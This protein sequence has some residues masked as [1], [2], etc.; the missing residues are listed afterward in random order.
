[1]DDAARSDP[2]VNLPAPRYA[3]LY[4]WI[5]TH[6]PQT[7]LE[8]GIAQADNAWNMLCLTRSSA[9]YYGFDLF[10]PAP[11]HEL[12][13][14][15]TI[16]VA[17][18]RRRLKLRPDQFILLFEGDTRE[19]MPKM[20]PCLPPQDLIFV[21]GGHSAETMESDFRHV[22]PLLAPGGAL[23]IDDYWPDHEDGGCKRVIDGLDRRAWDVHFCE[24]PDLYVGAYQYGTD[25]RVS[26]VRL[27]RPA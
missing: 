14:T 3:E 27:T 13:R 1:M 10:R 25:L 2:R 15:P 11:A 20:A 18:T 22:A 9:S 24:P 4:D 21:D 6:Q 26:M 23:F 5:R 7:L 12:D 17:E 16:T 8:I 19:T